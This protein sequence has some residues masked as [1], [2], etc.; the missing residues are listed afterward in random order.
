MEFPDQPPLCNL[1][2]LTE[3]EVAAAVAATKTD[4]TFAANPLSLDGPEVAFTMHPVH[5]KTHSFVFFRERE[6]EGEKV[7]GFRIDGGTREHR[8]SACLSVMGTLSRSY[9][10]ELFHPDGR[11]AVGV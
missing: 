7:S 8:Q 11:R 10:A 6:G 3:A 4:L 5:G 9:R 1:V 2:D